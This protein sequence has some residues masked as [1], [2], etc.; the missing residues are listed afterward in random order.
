MG[1]RRLCRRFCPDEIVRGQPDSRG[2]PQ[3][4]F[5]DTADQARD[6][7]VIDVR[8]NAFGVGLVAR[9]EVGL[10]RLRQGYGGQGRLTP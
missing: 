3:A 1:C 6:A 10:I 7:R 2:Y 4:G 9:A 8:S 5:Q